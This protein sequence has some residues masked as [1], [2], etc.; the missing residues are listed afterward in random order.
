MTETIHF[1]LELLKITVPALVVF[2]TAYYLVKKHL[3]SAII[4]RQME[5]KQSA[6][7]ATT[8][9]KMQA[10]ERLAMFCERSEIPSLLSRFY[11]ADLRC[12][13]LLFMMV[14]AI[15]QEYEHN[16]SQQVYVSD[17]LWKIIKLARNQ[18]IAI[19]ESIGTQVGL[20]ASASDLYD[21]VQ[22]HLQEHPDNPLATAQT[23]IRQEASLSL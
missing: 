5:L 18:N 16:I 20:D 2:A 7:H 15:K 8:P 21:A 22:A 12:K 13:E 19:L 9:M 1:F 10:Y 17:N 4:M 14:G 3:D 11:D 6:L 23:A